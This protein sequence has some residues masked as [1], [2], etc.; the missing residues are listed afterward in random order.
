LHHG[1]GFHAK[2]AEHELLHR[3]WIPRGVARSYRGAPTAPGKRERPAGRGLRNQRM[4]DLHLFLYRDMCAA[5][6]YAGAADARHVEDDY[7]EVA[8]EALRY[9]APYS[10]GLQNATYAQQHIGLIAIAAI[11][12]LESPVL[13]RVLADFHAHYPCATFVALEAARHSA[14]SLSA[15][16]CLPTIPPLWGDAIGYPVRG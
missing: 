6:V 8:R 10:H 1:I 2:A 11:G 16:R 13:K 12:D 9:R 5:R 3:I 4:D 15:R 7:R 14:A